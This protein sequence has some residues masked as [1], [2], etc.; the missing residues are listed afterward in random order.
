MG[1]G[2]CLRLLQRQW[3]VAVPHIYT[4]EKSSVE[5]IH[6]HAVERGQ[7]NSDLGHGISDGTE[8][9]GRRPPQ[10]FQLQ[11]D[12]MCSFPSYLF[13]FFSL[14]MLI[15]VI[16]SLGLRAYLSRRSEGSPL[17]LTGH[18]QS[19]DGEAGDCLI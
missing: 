9:D 7:C 6:V 15:C 18:K 4:K 14:L 13:F 3:Q 10:T 19:G 11:N 16:R 5:V 12:R 1:D 2:T 8:G 17:M